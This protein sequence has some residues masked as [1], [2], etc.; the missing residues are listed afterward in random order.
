MIQSFADKETKKVFHATH[1][2]KLPADIQR[3]AHNKLITLYACTTLELLRIPPSNRLEALKGSRKGQHSIRIN[4]QWR[5]C[6]RWENGNKHDVEI[7]A[8]H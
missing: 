5:I 7:T 4:Q 6:F 2:P 1:P 3:R 8:Y